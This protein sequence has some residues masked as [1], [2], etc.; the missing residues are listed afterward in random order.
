[1]SPSLVSTICSTSSST[2]KGKKKE[3][4]TGRSNCRRRKRKNDWPKFRTA[5][6]RKRE[7]L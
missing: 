4:S 2:P 7:V 5:K 6:L 1:M 3:L